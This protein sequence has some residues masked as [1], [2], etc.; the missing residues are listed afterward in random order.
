MSE[1]ARRT[2]LGREGPHK[3]LSADG[4]LSLA[5]AVRGTRARRVESAATPERERARRRAVL[6]ESSKN[7]QA[8]GM[9]ELTIMPGVDAA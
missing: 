3:A 4:N 8:S 9:L 6:A 7:N 1:S 5:T 2:G